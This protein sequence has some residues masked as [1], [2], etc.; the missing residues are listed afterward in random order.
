MHRSHQILDG[1]LL[2][3]VDEG[4]PAVLEDAELGA[5]PKVDRAAAELLLGQFR[6]D[7]D[8]ALAGDNA[9]YQC[10]REP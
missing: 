7:A 3:N 6:R 5:E 4:V 9:V 1:A 10:R 8:L 2:A